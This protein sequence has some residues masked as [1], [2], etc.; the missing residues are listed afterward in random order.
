MK[1]FILLLVLISTISAT[2]IE[3]SFDDGSFESQELS[4]SNNGYAQAFNMPGDYQ[5]HSAKV[6]LT[7]PS[8]RLTVKVRNYLTSSSIELIGIGTLNDPVS[9][10][11]EVD[12]SAITLPTPIPGR[13]LVE[14]YD[15]GGV[16]IDNTYPWYSYYWVPYDQPGVTLIHMLINDIGIR[17]LIEV[18]PS[19]AES[20]TLGELK[21]IY[22]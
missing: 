21:A 20:R 22:H 15:S 10:W 6:Y 3:M 8:P 9:G 7:A 12:L 18:G 14:A 19:A 17:L 2:I 13:L 5:L 16:G 4:D 1:C 11:N